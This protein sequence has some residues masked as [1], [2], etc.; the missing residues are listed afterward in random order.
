MS[1]WPLAAVRFGL[2]GGLGL[3]FG[4]PFFTLVHRGGEGLWRMFRLGRV[5]ILLA[6]LS[7]VL[8]LLGFL[9]LVA[10]MSA[11]P[12]GT[13]DMGLVQTL[14]AESAIGWAF[15]TRTAALL[16]G[17]VL[18][19]LLPLGRAKP[20]LLALCGAVA[21]ATLAWSGHGAGGEGMAGSVHLVSDVVHLLAASTW[22]GALAML[23]ALVLP[24]GKV[25]HERIEVAHAALADFGRTGT[26]VVVLIVLTGIANAAFIVDAAAL[27]TLGTSTYGRLLFVK[28]VFFA[29]MLGCA[30]LNRYRLTPALSASI[31]RGE[32]RP[33]LRDLRRSI[34]V[35]ATLAFAVLALVGWLGMLEPGGG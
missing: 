21:I 32:L 17:L 27:P 4:L 22:L 19:L 16:L 26:I 23:L 35:E 7:I 20:A 9:L 5:L 25:T 3:F 13:L 1:D 24:G 14:L 34:A 12:F 8:S 31:E 2:Y 18:A 30:A 10:R 6:G 29:A 15:V 33:S 28:L 11:T